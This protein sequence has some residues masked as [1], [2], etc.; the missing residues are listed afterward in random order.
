MQPVVN[1]T[2]NIGLYNGLATWLIIGC[3][4]F[5]VVTLRGGA[6]SL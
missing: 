3:S 1:P 5:L 4:C 2:H 6:L